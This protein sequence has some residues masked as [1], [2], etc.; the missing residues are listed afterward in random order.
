MS[1]P[2][3]TKE[4][5]TEN[6]NGQIG[7]GSSADQNWQ[8]GSASHNATQSLRRWEEGELANLNM[9]P[10]HHPIAPSQQMLCSVKT[11]SAAQEWDTKFV[12]ND[13]GEDTQKEKK[14]KKK[15]PRIVKVSG[16]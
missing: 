13:G 11:L 4:P 9:V 1:P 8:R 6:N 16:A 3:K 15:P 12:D 10:C 14:K 5:D 7:S 2:S